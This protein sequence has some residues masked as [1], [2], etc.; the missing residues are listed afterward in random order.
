MG[1]AA[2]GGVEGD[3]GLGL[4]EVQ[5]LHR[6]VQLLHKLVRVPHLHSPGIPL[7]HRIQA[8]NRCLPMKSPVQTSRSARSPLRLLRIAET[9]HRTDKN[10]SRTCI[11]APHDPS[12][13]PK[14]RNELQCS[15]PMST[16]EQLAE[17]QRGKE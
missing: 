1:E 14:L 10:C 12:H 13:L 11:L 6:Q 5:L 2:G 3:L 4:P 17:R 15:A 16:G 9:N 7:A 8:I